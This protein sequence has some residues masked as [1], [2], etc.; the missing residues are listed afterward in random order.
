[1]LN[2]SD[3]QETYTVDEMKADGVF[4]MAAYE[5]A[6]PQSLRDAELDSALSTPDI[7]VYVDDA[8]NKIHVGVRGTTPGANI[9]ETAH[10]VLRRGNDGELTSFEAKVAADI[11]KV[12]AKYPLDSLSFWTHSHGAQLVSMARKPYETATSFAGYI[13]KDPSTGKAMGANVTYNR[14]QKQK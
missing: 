8:D 3:T 14:L 4:A 9:L 5:E 13:R 7:A 12:R 2:N 1:V 10:S 11:Q 6:R